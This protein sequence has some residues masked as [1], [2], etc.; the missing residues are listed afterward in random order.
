LPEVKEGLPLKD[1]ASASHKL[2]LGLSARADADQG[3]FSDDNAGSQLE[4]SSGWRFITVAVPT[5]PTQKEDG[6]WFK[7][8]GSPA[9]QR[10]QNQKNFLRVFEP[11]LD[12]QRSRVSSVP[13]LST[14]KINKSR[15]WAAAKSL[16]LISVLIAALFGGVYVYRD[17]I[18]KRAH[19][20]FAST[21][22]AQ[23]SAD[24]EEGLAKAIMEMRKGLPKR[25]DQTTTLMWVSYS[26]TKMIFDNRLEIDGAKVDDSI[27]KKLVQLVT[28]NTC[29]SPASR[30]LLDLGGSY[31]YVY[32]DMHAKIVL[33]LDIDK[34]QCS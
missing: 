30:K 32:S 10:I 16:S 28:V 34:N 8:D 14:S 25:I 11:L 22:S 17:V 21:S 23:F 4:V 7:N 20:I 6:C 9:W 27:K 15:G 31:R 12:D 29:T 24:I 33:T 5:G 19:E 18:A 3:G 1:M 26:G 13:A 2:S